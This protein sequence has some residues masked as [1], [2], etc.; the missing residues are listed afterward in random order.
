MDIQ[1]LFTAHSFKEANLLFDAAPLTTAEMKSESRWA[2]FWGCREGKKTCPPCYLPPWLELTDG[3]AS[4]YEERVKEE[5]E[6]EEKGASAVDRKV[7]GTLA[8]IL[9]RKPSPPK[10]SSHASSSSSSPA[11][12]SEHENLDVCV[13]C[14]LEGEL[15]CCDKCPRSYCLKC[16]GL[17]EPPSEDPYHCG[18]CDVPI[19]QHVQAAHKALQG[20]RCS[21]GDGDDDDEEDD[22][23]WASNLV[24]DTDL[25]DPELSF[26]DRTFRRGVAKPVQQS[27]NVGLAGLLGLAPP[28]SDTH[29]N[30]MLANLKSVLE[31][32]DEGY[33]TATRSAF[34]G[35]PPPKGYTGTTDGSKSSS[36]S[37]SAEAPLN[38]DTIAILLALM[39]SGVALEASKAAR[40]TA[41]RPSSLEEAQQLLVLAIAKGGTPPPPQLK[42][43]GE[44]WYRLNNTSLPTASALQIIA[45]AAEARKEDGI[46]LMEEEEGVEE[47]EEEEEG[48]EEEEE[49]E[50]EEE[51]DAG[52]IKHGERG[53]AAEM[54]DGAFS[55]SSSVQNPLHTLQSLQSAL[56]TGAPLAALYRA[57][58]AAE[59]A[60]FRSL[61]GLTE[62]A[63]FH[64][65]AGPGE[66]RRRAEPTAQDFPL[67]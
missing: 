9:G 60:A 11:L 54:G 20:T 36:S 48:V 21:V 61:A 49:E 39:N 17:T 26:F 67:T 16:A 50:E 57:L 59:Q 41:W 19:P 8:S 4:D 24:D 33:A 28:P 35:A 30:R 32:K 12:A 43:L 23:S 5:E 53:G 3:Q 62:A 31:E 7:V 18:E 2:A 10:S 47:E 46:E 14:A 37:S 1:V 58:S 40:I 63:P 55:S 65:S 51:G 42:E 64:S 6:A 15:F 22:S 34:E 44:E 45:T 56:A 13:R 38:P 66:K 29:H 27:A 25:G 52:S